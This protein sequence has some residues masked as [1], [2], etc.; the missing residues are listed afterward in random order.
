MKNLSIRIILSVLLIL[1]YSF[2]V[3][4]KQ[5]ADSHVN[6]ESQPDVKVLKLNQVTPLDD[7][8]VETSGLIYFDNYFWTINDSGNENILYKLDPKN[9][10][11]VAELKVNNS[12]NMDWEELTQDR[13]YIYIADIGDNALA[14]AEKQIYRIKKSD[15]SQRTVSGSGNSEVIR[16]TYPEVDGKA[17]RFDAE[18]LVSL[19][20]SL[21]LFTKDLFESNHF[22]IPAS[23]GKTTAKFA[24]KFKSNGQVTG[25]ALDSASNTLLLVGYFGFGQRLLWEFKTINPSDFLA[26]QPLAFSLGGVTETGQLEAICFTP[27]KKVFMTNEE[28]GGLKQQLWNLPYPLQ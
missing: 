15:L 18:A 16:F 8:V 2:N 17:E 27:E 7:K 23:P 11:V 4:C 26:N 14:R 25:A 20:G 6:E 22:I 21:H 28:F 5:P 19:N 3:H 1:T 10:S 9:G 12:E 24:G 13:D